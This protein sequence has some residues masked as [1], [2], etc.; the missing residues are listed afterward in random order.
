MIRMSWSWLAATDAEVFTGGGGT[1][2]A[3]SIFDFIRSRARI[4]IIRMRIAMATKRMRHRNR[5]RKCD[6]SVAAFKFVAE[7]ESTGV[8]TTWSIWP[9]EVQPFPVPPGFSGL[10][11]G[12]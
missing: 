2:S 5:Q 12:M 3:V 8:A 9:E 7:V 1:T 10:E 4:P 6:K 11:S